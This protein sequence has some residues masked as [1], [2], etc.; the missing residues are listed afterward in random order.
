M[1][2]VKE[3]Q[4]KDVLIKIIREGGRKELLKLVKSIKEVI[5]KIKET[6]VRI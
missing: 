1:D 3:L 6:E 2:K 4:D 5:D